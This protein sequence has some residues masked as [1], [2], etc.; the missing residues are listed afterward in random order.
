V[1]EESRLG[2]IAASLSAANEVVA[3]E[4]VPVC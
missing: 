2:K 1:V 4:L 3:H